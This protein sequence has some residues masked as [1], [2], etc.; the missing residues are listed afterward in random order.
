VS[1]NEKLWREYG[2]LPDAYE[3]ADR[4]MA[5]MMEAVEASGEIAERVFKAAIFQVRVLPKLAPDAQERLAWK[6]NREEA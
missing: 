1:P 2:L 4:A 6:P 5:K 3:A